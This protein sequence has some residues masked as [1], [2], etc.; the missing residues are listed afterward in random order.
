MWGKLIV[1]AVLAL[2]FV[3]VIKAQNECSA[4]SGSIDPEC[5]RSKPYC[6][7]DQYRRCVECMDSCDCGFNEY[8]SRQSGIVTSVCYIMTVFRYL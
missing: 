6:I 5:P 1:I 4:S 2:S 3:R 8:C 7:N